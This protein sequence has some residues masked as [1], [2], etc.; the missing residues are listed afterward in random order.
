VFLDNT[1]FCPIP[2]KRKQTTT[3]LEFRNLGENVAV[4]VS[5]CCFKEIH[6]EISGNLLIR[7]VPLS[8][9]LPLSL[10]ISF[11][12]EKKF[13]SLLDISIL[14]PCLILFFSRDSEKERN[15]ILQNGRQA[16][17]RLPTRRRPPPTTTHETPKS[18]P[19]M[20][21]ISR[22]KKTLVIASSQKTLKTGTI[23]SHI[24]RCLSYEGFNCVL[25]IGFRVWRWVD[26]CC[27]RAL[28]FDCLKL[29]R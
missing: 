21:N 1:L 5:I 12:I 18:I 6:W 10:S 19:F 24:W 8:L 7:I 15:L 16:F 29:R 11:A 26:V 3:T 20:H 17:H 13:S 25:E 9:S 28:K 23:I 22:S 27:C 14:S 2:H 4:C